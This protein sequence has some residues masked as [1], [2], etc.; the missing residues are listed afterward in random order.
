MKSYS[1]KLKIIQKNKKLFA[2][3]GFISPYINPIIKTAFLDVWDSFHL[4]CYAQ[5][6]PDGGTYLEIGSWRGGSLL[7][8]FLGTKLSGNF[9][10][11]I[12]IDIKKEE[13]I[14]R[15]TKGIP[16]IRFIRS[17]SNNAHERILNRSADLLFIDGA[18]HYE[19][20]KNDIRNYW[21]KLKIGGIL[22]GHDYSQAPI[23]RGVVKAANEA[24]GK[25]LTVL[26][27][28]RIFMV[29]KLMNFVQLRKQWLK[30]LDKR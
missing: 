20:V 2:K 6:I 18:H 19:Q 26:E 12:G 9:V 22:L 16:D 4:F 27:N 11:F 10:S 15:N 14:L 7:C 13:K 17:R 1:E 24:F 25:R 5:K 30:Q 29:R 3:K 8:A 28:S 21:P 23:H